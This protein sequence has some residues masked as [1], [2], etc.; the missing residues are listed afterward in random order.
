MMINL[1]TANERIEERE[2]IEEMRRVCD[3]NR[4][5]NYLNLSPVLTLGV[6]EDLYMNYYNDKK[7]APDRIKL[8]E[9]VYN[10][11]NSFYSEKISR[12]FF[13]IE[14]KIKLKMLGKMS[15]II[16]DESQNCIS[17]YNTHYISR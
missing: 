1:L 17:V 14:N 6:I 16:N 11:I 12:D 13:K 4:F 5:I 9:D 7:I 15:I 2:R 10:S 8:D 3:N